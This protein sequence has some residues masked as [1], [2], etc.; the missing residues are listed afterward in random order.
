V[1]KIA[2]VYWWD[3]TSTITTVQS[4][5]NSIT[6]V[7]AANAGITVSSGVGYLIVGTDDSVAIQ[8]ALNAAGAKRISAEAATTSRQGQAAQ[9]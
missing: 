9:K 4:V 1:G 7:L 2:I 5:T 3:G 6:I 8:V